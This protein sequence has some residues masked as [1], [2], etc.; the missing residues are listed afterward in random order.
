M[1]KQNFGIVMLGAVLAVSVGVVQA[2]THAYSHAHP[3][4]GAFRIWAEENL[5][6]FEAKKMVHEHH[7]FMVFTHS[8]INLAAKRLE[9][10]Q[11]S[12]ERFKQA[13]LLFE[14][15]RHVH[16]NFSGLQLEEQLT[17]L[18]HEAEQINTDF[19]LG[20]TE[21]KKLETPLTACRTSEILIEMKEKSLI[22]EP[23]YVLFTKMSQNAYSVRGRAAG[24][25]I[26]FIAGGN[27]HGG[28][29]VM[30]SALGKRHKFYAFSEATDV[31]SAGLDVQGGIYEGEVCLDENGNYKANWIKEKATGDV[32]RW[33]MLGGFLSFSSRSG[34]DSVLKGR[35][36][37]FGSFAAFPLW[38]GV[39]LHR[40]KALVGRD[41]TVVENALGLLG[42]V[43]K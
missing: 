5:P 14:K 23:V 20:A 31:V 12:E 21:L 43:G 39:H 41:Y 18:H 27:I 28:A 6:I 11:V 34:S 33:A 7:D 16:Q 38:A 30:T 4:K 1:K 17:V 22:S 8:I 19:K 10:P 32:K 13:V 37:T 3:K 25:G 15:L 36:A 24:M 2:D 9:M 29:G 40:G 26:H 35:F 42:R